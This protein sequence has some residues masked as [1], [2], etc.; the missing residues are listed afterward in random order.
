MDKE[1]AVRPKIVKERYGTD[2]DG[3]RGIWVKWY[4]CPNCGAEIDFDYEEEN[5]CSSCNQLLDLGEE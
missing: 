3:N 2:R 5:R 4:E 1:K